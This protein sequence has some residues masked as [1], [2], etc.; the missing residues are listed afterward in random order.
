MKHVLCCLI[1]LLAAP[2]AAVAS[3]PTPAARNAAV[4]L[5][6]EVHDNPA[7][8]QTQAEWVAALRPAA[9]VFE[10]LTPEQAAAA[11]PALRGDAA[12]LEQALDWA[13]SGWPAFSMYFPIFTAAPA[14]KIYGA[15]VPRAQAR[16]A[17]MQGV[18]QSFGPQ[19]A[20]YGLTQPLPPDQQQ[21][22]EAM[23]ALS[24][25]NALPAEMLPGMVDVQRLRD[26]AL[27]RAALQALDD[28]AGPV[29]VITGNGHARSDWG[30]PAYLA[31]LRP[32]LAVFALGQSEAGQ[33]DGP[34]D[35]VI[36]AAPVPRDDPC[37]AF[38]KD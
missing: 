23:Q 9:L 10:M 11:T 22:R 28:T 8:H 16:A 12:A 38:A 13:N 15:A 33:I 3:A 17:L 36:D 19:A 7:H 35:L 21:Q 1:I 6:G 26:A 34:F 31:R 4:V 30:V 24:H 27:A 29:V 2:F 14:A 5:L 37:A 18:A 25:C 20:D 32:T